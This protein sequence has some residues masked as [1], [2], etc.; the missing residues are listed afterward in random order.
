MPKPGTQI[1]ADDVRWFCAELIA[2]YKV[3]E[4]IEVIN[5]LLPAQRQRQSA[6][7]C[8]KGA[9]ACL[10]KIGVFSQITA[11][12]SREGN[13]L[14]IRMLIIAGMLIASAGGGRAQMEKGANSFKK[15]APCHN[16]GP[17]ATNNVGPELNGL[18]GRNAGTVP[19]FDYSDAHKKSGLVWSEKSFKEYVKDPG[20]ALSGVSRVSRNSSRTPRPKSQVPR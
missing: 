11:N 18:D 1:V 13:G 14:M 6:E 12:A 2:D 16:I 10:L 4:T 3:P 15:C 9:T 20:R 17:G 19:N 8:S 5:D 7:A